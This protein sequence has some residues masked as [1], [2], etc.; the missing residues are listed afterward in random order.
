MSLPFSDVG[1][2]THSQEFR[3]HK[4]QLL[5]PDAQVPWNHV[6]TMCLLACERVKQG[7]SSGDKCNCSLRRIGCCRSNPP[8][9]R[10]GQT[11][12]SFQPPS[13][14]RLQDLG[15]IIESPPHPS[16]PSALLFQNHVDALAS[17]SIETSINLYQSS[18]QIGPGTSFTT[19]RTCRP[20][21]QSGGQDRQASRHQSSWRRKLQAK[22]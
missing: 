4:V 6:Q 5:G 14:L 7:R 10:Q 21:P 1:E 20:Q 3:V 16:F 8:T 12:S 9:P 2:S 15:I 17:L 18:W 11:G 22:I 19:G 13:F